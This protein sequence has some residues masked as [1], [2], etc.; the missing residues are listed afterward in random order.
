MRGCKRA[1]ICTFATFDLAD[2]ATRYTGFR[3]LCVELAAAAAAFPSLMP[4][5]I[6]VKRLFG[7]PRTG[8]DDSDAEAHGGQK[9]HLLPECASLRHGDD[10]A[11]HNELTQTAVK[12][13]PNFV[14]AHRWCPRLA[15]LA[16]GKQALAHPNRCLASKAKKKCRRISVQIDALRLNNGRTLGLLTALESSKSSFPSASPEDFRSKQ[17]FGRWPLC[18]CESDSTLSWEKGS[19]RN[20]AE[21]DENAK[22]PFSV[23]RILTGELLQSER[24][25]EREREGGREALQPHFSK[26]GRK[27]QLE[28]PVSLACLP[29]S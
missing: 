2:M 1:R 16:N 5:L 3:L 17:V 6:F 24:E 26:N 15:K 25:G 18:K 4:N 29:E 20:T 11:S 23:C 9:E 21:S 22:F 10:N 27:I 7:S 12:Q 14:I 13:R 8:L 28:F 19:I